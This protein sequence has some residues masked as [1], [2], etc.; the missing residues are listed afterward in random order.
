MT[1]ADEFCRRRYSKNPHGP[2]DISLSCTAVAVLMGVSVTLSYAGCPSAKKLTTRVKDV[3]LHM[4]DWVTEF[5]TLV[6]DLGL[7]LL[8]LGLLRYLLH[9]RRGNPRT[10][11][12]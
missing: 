8:P 3:A 10:S 2:R 1:W 7:D 9:I 5:L 6:Q 4:L 11:S 12:L